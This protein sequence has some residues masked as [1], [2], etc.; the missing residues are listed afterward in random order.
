VLD[1]ARGNEEVD[2]SGD[3]SWAVKKHGFF[4]SN[5]HFLALVWSCRLR[6]GLYITY[7][8]LK[9][10]FCSFYWCIMFVCIQLWRN[11]FCLLNKFIAKIRIFDA[12]HCTFELYP[13]LDIFLKW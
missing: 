7:I 6:V 8:N 1:F 12:H 10:C 13:P 2:G 9:L 4:G 3:Q 11:P 5:C